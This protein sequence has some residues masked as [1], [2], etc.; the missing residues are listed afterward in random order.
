[1][2][3][4]IAKR[5]DKTYAVNALVDCSLS[6]VDNPYLQAASDGPDRA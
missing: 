4:R 3:A 2:V 1:M 6:A 5:A